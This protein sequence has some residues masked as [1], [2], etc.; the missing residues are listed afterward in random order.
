MPDG[1]P[2]ASIEQARSFLVG[3]FDWTVDRLVRMG[4]LVA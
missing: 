3:S 4:L 2:A 1:A